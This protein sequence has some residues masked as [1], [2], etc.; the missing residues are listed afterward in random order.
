M[1][2]LFSPLFDL[3]ALWF[4]LFFVALAVVYLL[5]DRHELEKPFVGGFFCLLILTSVLGTHFFPFMVWDKFPTT[6]PETETD[7]ELRV[8]T[9]DNDE[10]TYDLLA[11]LGADGVYDP[12]LTPE[13]AEEY[14]HCKNIQILAYLLNRARVYR[15]D[16]ERRSILTF[17]RFPPHGLVNL[18]DKKQLRQYDEFVGVRLYAREIQSSPDG[19]EASIVSEELAIEYLE[20]EEYG[21]SIDGRSG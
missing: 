20:S 4:V 2:N 14:P 9:E 3:R 21:C 12:Y 11:T 8:V 17:A 15:G 18:W 16:V 13:M 5:K 6:Y 7:Y 10:L 1:S 19:T